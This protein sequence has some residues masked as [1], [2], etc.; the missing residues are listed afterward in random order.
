MSKVGPRWDSNPQPEGCS[1]DDW[2]G[3]EGGQSLFNSAP[4]PHS[5]TQQ[6]AIGSSS[7]MMKREN[8]IFRSCQGSGH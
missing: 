5:E 3:G 1:S 2:D 6:A 4:G 8:S 7:S